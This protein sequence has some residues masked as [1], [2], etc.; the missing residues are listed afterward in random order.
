MKLKIIII[1]LGLIVAIISGVKL[2]DINTVDDV[3]NLNTLAIEDELKSDE[4]ITINEN[5]IKENF[6]EIPKEENLLQP[7]KVEENNEK[8]TENVEKIESNTKTNNSSDKTSNIQKELGKETQ[9]KVPKK[10][11]NNT[12]NVVEKPKNEVPTSDTKVPTEND[13]EYWCVAGGSHHIAGDGK[14]EH[15]YYSTWEEAHKAFIEY[16]KDWKSV[17][18]KISSC[19]CGQYYFWAIK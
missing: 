9:E 16:T 3:K 2:K 10:D 5:E 14:D 6:D 7:E 8:S 18:F 13:L 11:S 15:G 19:P 4:N 1:T 12:A 17:Q